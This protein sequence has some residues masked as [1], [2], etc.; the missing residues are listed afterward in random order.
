LVIPFE[1]S[2]LLL[3]TWQQVV[4]LE[5]DNRPRKRDVVVQIMGE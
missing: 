3:G 5:F 2:K 1:K 4:L